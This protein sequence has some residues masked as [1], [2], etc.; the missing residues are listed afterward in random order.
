MTA[1][2]NHNEKLSHNK[3][4]CIFNPLR[5]LFLDNPTTPTNFNALY[6][7][8]CQNI[9]LNWTTP[10]KG[11]RCFSFDIEI[12]SANFITSINFTH[13]C[14][15]NESKRVHKFNFAAPSKLNMDINAEIKVKS[16]N[17]YNCSN[18]ARTK[19]I[20]GNCIKSESIKTHQIWSFYSDTIHLFR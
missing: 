11:V 1:C 2:V 19:I 10:G 12:S 9:S 4:Y 18:P 15:W 14:T 6:T 17:N 13:N 16:C 3:N 8:N 20:P 7:S 5:K